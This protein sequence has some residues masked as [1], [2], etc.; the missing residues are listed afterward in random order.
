MEWEYDCITESMMPSKEAFN[1]IMRIAIGLTV[2]IM[3][4]VP[5]FYRELVTG[6]S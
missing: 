3:L 5:K 4:L 1:E 6:G 2:P